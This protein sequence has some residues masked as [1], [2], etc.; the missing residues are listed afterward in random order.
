MMVSISTHRLPHASRTLLSRLLI[1]KCVSS[2]NNQHGSFTTCL[3]LNTVCLMLDMF[4]HVCDTLQNEKT[5][6]GTCFNMS[7]TIL[8]RTLITGLSRSIIS[9][10]IN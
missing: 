5:A 2:K 10:S 4:G 6:S 3:K 7:L 8:G 9:Q 1:R